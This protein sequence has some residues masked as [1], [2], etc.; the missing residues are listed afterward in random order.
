MRSRHLWSVA[1]AGT[2]IRARRIRVD[3]E[4][5]IAAKLRV[6]RSS[7]LNPFTTTAERVGTAHEGIGAMASGSFDMQH[8]FVARPHDRTTTISRF[9]VA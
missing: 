6:L 7:L 8:A 1:F 5:C 9:V 2:V 3:A 4:S